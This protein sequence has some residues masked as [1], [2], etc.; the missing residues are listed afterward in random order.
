MTG[1]DV[2]KRCLAL[3][4]YTL[5]DNEVLAEKSLT[6]RM[7]ELINYIA[8]ELHL[9]TIKKLS[10][11]IKGTSQQIEALCAGS[12]MLF[13]LSEGDSEKNK[14]F[15]SIYNA[16]RG[17]ILSRSEVVSDVLPKPLGGGM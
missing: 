8:D 13:A 7:P 10:D 16:K 3:M 9:P 17:A 11:V 14:V 4:G 2:Y 6:T 1:F 5:E 15:S 12:V